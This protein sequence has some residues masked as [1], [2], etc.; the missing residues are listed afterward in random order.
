MWFIP[1]VILKLLLLDKH[2]QLTS[3]WSVFTEG[4]PT[5]FLFLA[6]SVISAL[7]AYYCKRLSPEGT[8]LLFPG[9]WLSRRDFTGKWTLA[10]SRW[11]YRELVVN[12]ILAF[13][14]ALTSLRCSWFIAK[15]LVYVLQR[16]ETFWKATAMQGHGIS[17]ETFVALDKLLSQLQLEAANPA[18]C[19]FIYLEVTAIPLTI[20]AVIFLYAINQLRV[21]F[22]N[23]AA[24]LMVA[25]QPRA[26]PIPTDKR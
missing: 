6:V 18:L 2:G 5:A 14:I 8:P 17:T 24:A 21:M 25:P 22:G 10:L 15:G 20:T 3:I 1:L 19:N 13:Y 9:C 16:A 26:V 11:L 4:T 7:L 23:A 12:A